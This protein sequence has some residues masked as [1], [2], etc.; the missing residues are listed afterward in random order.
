MG[1]L[2]DMLKSST[3]CVDEKFTLVTFSNFFRA[4]RKPVMLRIYAK[5]FQLFETD[6]QKNNI[7]SVILQHLEAAVET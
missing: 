5:N 2:N 1:I 3:T 7:N 4:L 6:Y